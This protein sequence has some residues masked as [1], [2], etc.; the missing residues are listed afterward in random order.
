MLLF[1]N[2]IYYTNNNVT[3]Q[4]QKH[5]TFITNLLQLLHLLTYYVNYGKMFLVKQFTNDNF[6]SC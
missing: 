2:Y 1:F 6:V 5:Y 4:E 3:N